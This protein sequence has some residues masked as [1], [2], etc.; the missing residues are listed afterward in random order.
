MTSAVV[1]YSVR[2]RDGIHN[3]NDAFEHRSKSHFDLEE[4][5]H[6]G[7]AQTQKGWPKTSI[8]IT[9]H[10]PTVLFFAVSPSFC[11]SF[12]LGLIQT[13]KQTF[14]DDSNA[15]HIIGQKYEATV[16]LV[17]KY[18]YI[19]MYVYIYNNE[20]D[21][22]QSTVNETQEYDRIVTPFSREITVLVTWERQ[23]G[24]R[25]TKER[26]G[27]KTRKEKLRIIIIKKKKMCDPSRI[28]RC[29]VVVESMHNR[30][31]Y[32]FCCWDMVIRCF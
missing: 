23:V 28:G 6:R 3:V 20:Y 11:R 13:N 4:T 24:Q 32:I 15:R 5:V 1:F 2:H 26:E 14:L 25:W 30:Y 27:T 29:I 7:H 22:P 16:S 8:F 31:I 9:L 19:Y 10:S 12:S 17:G 21:K 18:M